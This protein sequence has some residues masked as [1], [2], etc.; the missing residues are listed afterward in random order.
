MSAAL[1]QLRTQTRY[2]LL[3]FRR[4]PAAT[5]FT[6]VLPLVF[7]VIFTSIFG[8]DLVR[9][10]SGAEVRL[11]NFYVPGILSLAL[12]SATTVNLAMSNTSKRERGILKR[13]RGSPMRTWVYV[14]AELA[15]GLFIVAVMTVLVVGLGWL[16][17]NVELRWSGV[18]ALVVSL[19]LASLAF[20]SLGLALC[21]IIASE[22]AAPAVTNMIVLPLYFVSDVFIISDADTPRLMTVV[23]DVFP[24]KHLAAAL[25]DAF[26]PLAASTSLP[27]AD[28][29]VVAAWG[30]FGT[31]VALFRF[32]WT[33]R[34]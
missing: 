26:D 12:V 8:N 28:W 18:P 27:W 10:A 17:F 5:F 30:V 34:R 21:S 33:P 7:L 31:A 16:L 3:S 23:G 25:G 1:A 6:V 22:S 15:S 9:S 20:S 13:L 14:G 11:A 24:I 4:N 32:R 2:T 29:A 19:V